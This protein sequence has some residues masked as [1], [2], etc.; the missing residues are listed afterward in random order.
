MPFWRCC[1]L[2]CVCICTSEYPE[3]TGKQKW[4]KRWGGVTWYHPKY[5]WKNDFPTLPPQKYQEKE[6]ERPIMKSS[7]AIVLRKT[8]GGGGETQTLMSWREVLT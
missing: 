5:F 2:I 8:K 6:Q 1:D 7:S 3:N 4:L